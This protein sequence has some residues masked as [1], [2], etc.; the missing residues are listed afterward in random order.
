MNTKEKEPIER[1]DLRIGVVV[2]AE[3]HPNADTMYVEQID[4]GDLEGP[5]TIVS[6]LRNHI[7]L[8]NFIGKQV[9]VLCN[10]KPRYTIHF[11]ILIL[12]NY[13]YFR[14]LRGISSHG[15]ILCASNADHTKVELLC[16][17]ENVNPGERILI[18]GYDLTEPD[19]RLNP[20]KKYW[21]SCEPDMSSRKNHGAP[22]ACYKNIPLTVGESAKVFLECKTLTE[23][24][25][26]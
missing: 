1:L 22:V 14:K 9:L 8:E 3:I 15:M 18:D 21:E 17:A 16:P 19:N 2:S 23:F 11:L 6:G 20:K 12:D 10:L 25:M 5:R 7:P 4:V 26:G 24:A 13:S